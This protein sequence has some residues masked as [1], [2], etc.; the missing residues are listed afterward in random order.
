VLLN[1]KKTTPEAIEIDRLEL[2][3]IEL[4]IPKENISRL[5]NVIEIWLTLNEPS[6][7]SSET[8]QLFRQDEEAL[9]RAKRTP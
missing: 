1:H 6:L 3:K 4:E 5:M 7:K 9:G 8:D 2:E